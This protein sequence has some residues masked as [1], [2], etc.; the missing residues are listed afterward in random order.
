MCVDTAG[1][2]PRAAPQRRAPSRQSP[3]AWADMPAC[4]CMQSNG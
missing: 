3:D 1:S 2:I 4:G